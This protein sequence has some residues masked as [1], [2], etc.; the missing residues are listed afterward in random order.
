MNYIRVPGYFPDRQY[1]QCVLGNGVDLLYVDWSGAMS[2]KDHINGIFSYWYKLDRKPFHRS[3]PLPLLRI[4]YCL[5]SHAG[6]IEI[7]DSK[8]FFDPE[9]A[10]LTSIISADPFKFTVR[11]FVTENH[12]FVLQFNFKKF[13]EGSAMYF[14]IDDNRITYTKKLVDTLSEPVKYSFENS[15]MKAEYNHSGEISFKGAGMMDVIIPDEGKKD[16]LST[17]DAAFPYLASGKFIRVKNLKSGSKLYC[18]TCVMDTLDDTDY[19][20][21]IYENIRQFKENGFHQTYKKHVKF[22]E[23][24]SKK[25][26]VRISK[27]LDYLYKLSAY[28][29]KAVQFPTGAIIPSSVFPN[30]HGCLVYWDALFDQM[31]FLRNNHIDE[32][33]KIAE[34]WLYGLEKARENARKL[35][36]K[37]AYYGWATDF[38]GYDSN[39]IKSNQVHFNGDISLSCWKYYEYTK[40]VNYLGEV[41]PVMKETIDFLISGY[42]EQFEQGIRVKSC[43]SLDESS[44]ERTSDTWTT[45]LI[46]KGIENII[47]AARIL[48]ENIDELEYEKTKKGLIDAL[49]RN[50]K[51]GILYSHSDFGDLNAGSI[52]AMLILDDIRGVDKMKT[53]NK[54]IRDVKEQYGLGWGHSSRMRCRISPWAEFMAAIFLSKN[55]NVD[56][57]KYIENS[58]KAT[59]SFGG[60]AEYFWIHSLI[61]RNWYVS[62]HGTFLW[63]IAEMLVSSDHKHIELFPGLPEDRIRDTGFKNILAHDTLVSGNVEKDD[64]SLVIKNTGQTSI[65]KNVCFKGR[66]IT[67]EIK[68]EG[69]IFLTLKRRKKWQVVK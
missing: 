63:A 38:Y 26:D 68:P 39:A 50:T 66:K 11:S 41:F 10:V 6:P 46:I 9:K 28:I 42:V 47:N 19:E 48:G 30:N 18:I 14:A 62:A 24:F 8:Q 51:N 35:G 13:P 53:F 57:W 52:L 56:A 40:D 32:A 69:K 29:C 61:S 17:S 55:N 59:D 44:Y 23:N 49:K 4:K 37:G 33:K 22:W 64:I 43:E 31:G 54:Y 60:F 7:D 12:I 58:A 3:D 25:S 67:V 34:F 45:A 36:A 15:M 5:V 16:F 20:R 27:D 65:T 21:K 2:F 1:C